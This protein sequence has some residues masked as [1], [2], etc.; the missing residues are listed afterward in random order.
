MEVTAG[1][2]ESN[3]SLL[4]GLW[5]DSPRLN[6][7]HS[8]CALVWHVQPRVVIFPCRT[9]Y[10]PSSLKCLQQ[11]MSFSHKLHYDHLAVGILVGIHCSLLAKV[12]RMWLKLAQQGAAVK[13]VAYSS[14]YV[15]FSLAGC[16]GEDIWLRDYSVL[17]FF[18]CIWLHYGMIDLPRFCC[19]YGVS[20]LVFYC[21]LSV[22]MLV[23]YCQDCVTL[24]VTFL[25]TYARH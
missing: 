15:I 3:G 10:R 4:P 8:G 20:K 17:K 14:K 23:N 1:L 19:D 12:M 24:L 18:C 11:L 22:F 5:R 21:L 7:S 6:M 9:H 2:A 13:S 25:L 16:H